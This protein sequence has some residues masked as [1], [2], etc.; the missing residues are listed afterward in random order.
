MVDCVRK[1]TVKKS[2]KCGEYGLFELLLFLFWY[3]CRVL[4]ACGLCGVYLYVCVCEWERER[5]RESIHALVC[6]YLCGHVC[7]CVYVCVCVCVCVCVWQRERERDSL[8]ILP[9]SLCCVS[10][11]KLQMV[12][13]G[14]HMDRH[15]LINTLPIWLPPPPPP[16]PTSYIKHIGDWSRT[17][18][19]LLVVWQRRTAK[20]E[21]KA[22]QMWF[23]HATY[24]R[25]LNQS[26][27]N[28]EY[29]SHLVWLFFGFVLGFFFVFGVG[30]SLFRR[31]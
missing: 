19:R 25:K 2:C 14:L 3:V 31:L 10:V 13:S 30:S 5:E 12:S 28:F 7:V 15:C 9:Y 1:V 6:A 16:P 29:L 23:Q 27:H 20:I 21:L 4:C 24:K 8:H 18:H 11:V 22:D 17:F 26:Y